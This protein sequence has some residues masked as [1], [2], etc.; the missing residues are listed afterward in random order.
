MPALMAS[1][2][3]ESFSSR[4]VSALMLMAEETDCLVAAV[5]ATSQL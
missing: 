2:P 4:V 5:E 3:A 1:A